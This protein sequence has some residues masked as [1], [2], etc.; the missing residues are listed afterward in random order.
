MV[1][2]EDV[3]AA[4]R[5]ILGREAENEEVISHHARLSA[6]V[7]DLRRKFLCSP[8][9]VQNA[10]GLHSP[11]RFFDLPPIEVDV[12]ASSEQL[13]KMIRHIESNWQR[14]GICDPH[15]SVFAIE[16]FRASNIA[17]T[18]KEFY[19]SGLL[20][21]MGLQRTAER[22]GVDLTKFKRCF[23][24]GCGVGR[25]TV[26]LADLFER[27]AAA[28]I[29]RAHLAL[30][31]EAL[32]TFS[33]G[34]VDL[35]HVDT[36]DAFHALPKFDFFCSLIVLQHN[37]PPLIAV[38]LRTLLNELRPGGIAYFQVPTY[39]S[40][41]GFRIEEYILNASP[42]RGMEMHLIPQSQ[43][44]DILDRSGCKVLECREDLWTGDYNVT[45]NSIFAKKKEITA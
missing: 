30:A 8:E 2:T 15:W 26:W 10:R 27:V 37:P 3:R 34:N 42:T 5:W 11:Q 6:S 22:C 21:V 36:F 1:S 35:I 45:S 13:A 40:G 24:L 32:D 20:D 44:F 38:L 43:L 29:S 18:R 7:E 9:F 41:Y 14:L 23:E 25:M 16:A 17:R 33:K 31:K 19:D 39:Q 4:Y 28:D 12:D